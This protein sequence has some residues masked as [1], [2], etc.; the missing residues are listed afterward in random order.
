MCAATPNTQNIYISV[1]SYYTCMYANIIYLKKRVIW[2]LLYFVIYARAAITIYLCV[3]YVKNNLPYNINTHEK[4]VIFERKKK[5]N[6]FFLYETKNFFLFLVFYA[7]LENIFKFYV[8][9]RTIKER[10]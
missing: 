7:E 9:H 6:I 3:Q 10:I 8:P 4:I 5:H 1:R 2:F